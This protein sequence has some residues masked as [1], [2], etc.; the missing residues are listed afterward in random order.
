MLA[1]LL[2]T[3]LT[4]AAQEAP[5]VAPDATALIAEYEA[6]R[7]EM[8]AAFKAWNDALPRDA[9][10]KL[11]ATDED[12]DRDPMPSFLPRFVELGRRAGATEAGARALQ[13]A[14]GLAGRPGAPGGGPALQR[15]LADL[16]VERFADS[17]LGTHAVDGISG[18]RWVLGSEVEEGLL[19][20]VLECTTLPEVKVT[21][22]FALAQVLFDPAYT[23]DEQG[24]LVAQPRADT[25]PARVLL[26]SLQRD[27]AGSEE[28]RRAA[29]L[30]FELDHLQVGMVAPDIEAV[31]QDGVAFKLSDYRGKV[32]LLVFWGFW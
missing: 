29:G 2:A 16:L 21:A 12:W 18:L 17:P 8:D 7:V 19:R 24:D 27:F 14:L 25:A 26:E 5:A 4:C 31:D 13:V 1:L 10:G 28:A 11:A 32:V 23:L 22:T 6:L 30:L 9:D 3:A 20:R 15:E